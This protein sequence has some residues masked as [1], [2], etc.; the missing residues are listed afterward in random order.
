MARYLE[1]RVASPFNQGTEPRVPR[2]SVASRRSPAAGPDGESLA[3]IA[4]MLRRF[5]REYAVW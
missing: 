4:E 2:E 5:L 3:L 1:G